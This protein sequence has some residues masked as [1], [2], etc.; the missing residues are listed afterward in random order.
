MLL[1]YSSKY[2]IMLE[3]WSAFGLLLV[4]LAVLCALPKAVRLRGRLLPVVLD[5][6]VD[7]NMSCMGFENFADDPSSFMTANF[8][9]K[10][11][12]GLLFLTGGESC[13]EG[14]IVEVLL[15]EGDAVLFV[16]LRAS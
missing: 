4:E 11:S 7:P 16:L 5:D 2:L 12:K 8:L 1:T 3:F 6:A 14:D 9:R 15:E 13:L 10:A